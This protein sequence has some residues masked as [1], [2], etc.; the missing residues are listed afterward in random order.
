MLEMFLPDF[1][2]NDVNETFPCFRV[3]KGE[4]LELD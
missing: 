3:I 2:N 1:R 4:T